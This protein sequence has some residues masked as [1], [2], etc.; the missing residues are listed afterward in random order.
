MSWLWGLGFFYAFHVT[1][2]HGWLGFLS[3]A[4]VNCV[5]LF[6]F[7]HALG[8]PGVDPEAR[9]KSAAAPFNAL[10]LLS[11]TLAVAITIF[12]LVAYVFAPLGLP[13]GASIAA[14]AIIVLVAC[15]VG[16]GVKLS[17]LALLHVGTLLAGVV[18][19][20]GALALLTAQGRGGAPLLALDERFVGMLIPSLVGFLLGPWTDLQQWRRAAEIR[21]AG[22]SPRIAYAGG[23]A[24]FFGLLCLN[25]AIAGAAGGGFAQPA[26]D[27]IAGHQGAPAAA[28]A[29]LKSPLA[30]GLYVAWAALAAI[31]TIDSAYEAIGWHLRG[32][33]ARSAS[34]LLG[35]VPNGLVTSPLWVIALAAWLAATLHSLGLSQIYLMVPYATL[36][37]G[38]ALALAATTFRP[39]AT[40]DAMLSLLIGSAALLLFAAGYAAGSGVMLTLSTLVATIG[41]WA[42]AAAWLGWSRPAAPAAPQAVAP[43]AEPAPAAT[44]P[45]PQ[46]GDSYVYHGFDDKWFVLHL[47][48]TYDDT[49]SVGNIYFANY[50]RWVGKARELFFNHCMPQF[51]LKTTPFYILTHSLRHD[52]RREAKEFEPITV[53]IRISAYNRKFVELEHEIYSDAQG[54]LGR[55]AQSLMFADSK[56]YT[57]VDFPRPVIEGFLPFL[58]KTPPANLYAPDAPDMAGAPA[59]AGSRQ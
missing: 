47:K 24:L 21:K 9:L 46:V 2:A 5:G 56:T 38:S 36:L 11:Q 19:G 58:P 55:G 14:A 51:D 53:K 8:A 25:A 18:C 52:F 48:P 27:G 7:G 50:I 39:A 31:S 3:F 28:L 41:G 10:F 20:V 13:P 49:N 59:A 15:A 6:L 29:A 42:A 22:L 23:A 16:Q 44:R 17:S 45:M 37:V 30:V 40:H 33:V 54:L 26:A 32:L 4:S 43:V 1:L 57:L 34:P 35:I 12:G